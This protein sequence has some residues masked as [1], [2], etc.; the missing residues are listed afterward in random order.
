MIARMSQRAQR[1]VGGVVLLVL[2][3][4]AIWAAVQRE[5]GITVVLVAVILVGAV[6][7]SI[8]VSRKQS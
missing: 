8:L 5:T 1:V 7:L 3:A 4:A 2:V 6:A